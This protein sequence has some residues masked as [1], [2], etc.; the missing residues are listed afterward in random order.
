MIAFRSLLSR[1][2]LSAALIA[3]PC[4]L[5]PAMATETTL[6]DRPAVATSHATE[7]L[8][9]GVTHAGSRL[10]AV[11]EYGDIVLSDDDGKTWRQ[12]KSVPTQVT[13]TAV[14]FVD[15]KT[16]WAVG[17]DTVILH[18]TDG[19]E[20]WA[21]QFGGGES[22]NA[23]LTIAFWD[24]NHGLAMGAFNFTA[25]TKDGGKTWVER[26]TL[27]PIQNKPATGPALAP[28]AGGPGKP[29][30]PAAA[31]VAAEPAA[32]APARHAGGG[33]DD[34][35]GDSK[36]P[37]AAATGDENHLNA[38]FVGPDGAMYVAAEA[39]A[40]FRSFDQGVTWDKVLTGYNGSFWGGFVAKDGSL[41]IMGMHGNIWHSTDR[42]A[43]WTKADT[44]AADQSV[45]AGIQLKDGK[46]VFVGL[47]G[48]VLY[49]DDGKKFTLTYRENRKG[50][51]AVIED[52]ADHLLIFG[53]SGIADQPTTPPL[54]EIA[55]P[56]PQG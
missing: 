45:A 16:G 3:S 54:N 40:V 33:A 37:Y 51:N 1:M 52:G 27:N 18:T 41:Y 10:V 50:L 6:G 19:G 20:T 36:D 35:G 43:S 8:L 53:E 48:Q 14:A 47:G 2:S 31:P 55:Q 44:G 24:P 56:L 23:L 49:S 34:A 30:A 4:L 12:A 17:H 29:A 38:A 5:G 25:E 32:A 39:G 15:D 11:G 42:G 26:K 21:K 7:A 22:D 9:L 46:F 28:G 13:L